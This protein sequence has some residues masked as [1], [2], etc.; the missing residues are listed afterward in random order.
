M[1]R[2]R[3]TGSRRRT[4]RSRGLARLVVDGAASP[5]T[6][7]T[8]AVRGTLT[9]TGAVRF[10]IEI[11]YAN[12]E[13]RSFPENAADPEYTAFVGETTEIWCERFDADPEWTQSLVGSPSPWSWGAP[14]GLAGDPVAGF[15]GANVLGTKLDGDG[16]YA[17]VAQTRV[18]TPMIDASM[19][20]EVRLQF[21]RWL[22]VEDAMYDAATVEVNG[23]ARWTNATG[24]G[25]LTHQ[26]REWRFVDIDVTDVASAPISVAWTIASDSSRALGGWNLDDV[27]L[28]GIDKIPT[29]GDDV[30]DE[31]EECD[32]DAECLSDCTLDPG[33]CSAGGD[34]RG[35]ALLVLGVLAVIAR[36]RKR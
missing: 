31:D 24:D 2:S 12:G 33:C 16:R 26:D 3:G 35:T 34:P 19:F 10:S 7:S 1:S 27:C 8:D 28:V 22:V 15:T 17:S 18:T 30:V 32:G 4:R 6:V 13:L 36:R 9:G 29:C 20:R 21:R 23:A 14:M 5:L 25:F 11:E